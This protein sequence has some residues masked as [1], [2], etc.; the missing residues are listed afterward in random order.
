MSKK[1]RAKNRELIRTVSERLIQ[2]LTE[3]LNGAALQYRII[4]KQ[5]G[6]GSM[7]V[8]IK[9]GKKD[10]GAAIRISDHKK[11]QTDRRVNFSRPVKRF[12]GIW[13]FSKPTEIDRKVQRIVA[14][15]I[16]LNRMWGEA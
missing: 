10:K 13:C 8:K 5:A 14:N 4:A 15:I 2:G 3:R 11:A 1:Q 12:Y 16:R 9:T 6:T 7:Y